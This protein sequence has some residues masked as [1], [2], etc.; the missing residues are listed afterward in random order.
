MN[1]FFLKPL[2]ISIALSGCL[3]TEDEQLLTQSDINV[4]NLNYGI[5][6]AKPLALNV[7]TTGSATFTGR[8]GFDVSEP[9]VR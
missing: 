3:S 8:A 2:A 7:P 6:E 5:Q 4:F 1:Q 9:D